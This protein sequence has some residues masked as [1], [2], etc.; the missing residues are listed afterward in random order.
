MV[1]WSHGH[2]TVDVIIAYYVTTTVFWIYHTLANNANLKVITA[3]LLLDGN[4]SFNFLETLS[5]SIAGTYL[6]EERWF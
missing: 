6:P 3:V 2:Y 1:L 5:S 4:S